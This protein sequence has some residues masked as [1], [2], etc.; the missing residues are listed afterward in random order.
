MAV[1]EVSWHVPKIIYHFTGNRKWAIRWWKRPFWFPK[2]ID[3]TFSTNW[4]IPFRS[5]CSQVL[6]SFR[7]F[8]SSI[9]DWR[10]KF[11]LVYITS[12][13][14]S[15]FELISD[16]SFVSNSSMSA[17]STSPFQNHPAYNAYPRNNP[18]KTFFPNWWISD[19][20]FAVIGWYSTNEPNG[21]IGPLNG[22]PK[23]LSQG[24]FPLDKRSVTFR[25]KV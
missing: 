21:T 25:R 2:K 24:V 12:F 8:D 10:N 3:G 15:L 9:C 22:C 1:Y 20:S 7:K 4:M 11:P 18:G 14:V 16:A 6:I 13:A 17:T 5:G 19:W 23:R